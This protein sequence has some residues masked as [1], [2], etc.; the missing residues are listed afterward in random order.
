MTTSLLSANVPE[1]ERYARHLES[2]TSAD[3]TGVARGIS[4]LGGGQ[5]GAFGVFAAQALGVPCRVAL[6]GLGDQVTDLAT[7]ISELA[8]A[9]R[10]AAHDVERTDEE[11]AAEFARFAWR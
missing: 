10:E 5:V 9:V 3:L 4:G 1:L 8:G 11:N 6:S 2:V 7:R